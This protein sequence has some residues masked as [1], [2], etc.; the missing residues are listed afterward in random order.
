MPEMAM[1]GQGD[2]IAK[3]LEGGLTTHG[4]CLSGICRG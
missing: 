3:L 2:E 1:F 4:V